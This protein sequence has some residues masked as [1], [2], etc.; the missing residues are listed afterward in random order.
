[1]IE[2]ALCST[3]LIL[4]FLGTFQFG[5]A[6]YQYNLLNSA[7]RGGVRYASLAKISNQGNGILSSAYILNVQNVVV[8]G[9]P[10]PTGSSTPII[11]GLTAANVDVSIGVDARFVPLTVTVKINTMTIDAIVKTF[12]I[13]G[14]PV[15]QMPFLGQYCPVGC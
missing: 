12:T 5:F 8:Y 11:P 10:T 1:M 3:L 7:V 15:L 2:F 14:K 4:F 6:F 13:T 9:T